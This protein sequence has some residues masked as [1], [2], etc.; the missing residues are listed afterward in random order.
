MKKAVFHDEEEQQGMEEVILSHDS[1]AMLYRVPWEVARDLESYCESFSAEWVWHG[2]EKEKF[3]REIGPGQQ[4]AAYGAP[5]FIDYLNRWVFPER[6][7]RLVKML[8][9]YG[10]DIPP[11]YQGTPHYNF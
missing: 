3:L 2:P 11:E 6:P 1:Q 10:Y 8:D 5:D 9:F 4:V 7:C